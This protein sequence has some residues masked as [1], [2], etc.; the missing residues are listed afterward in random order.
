[1]IEMTVRNAHKAGIKVCICGELGAD[2][3]LTE[4]FLRIG[5]DKLSV[6]PNKILPLR[7]KIICG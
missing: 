4:E 7:K 1:M 6:V 2:L 3:S 5:L